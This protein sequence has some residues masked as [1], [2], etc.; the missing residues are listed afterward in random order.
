MIEPTESGKIETDESNN[1]NVAAE[2]ATSSTSKAKRFGV[3]GG[4][5]IV[6]FVVLI[7]GRGTTSNSIS[8]R[9]DSIASSFK[10]P[11]C[12]G[13]SVA[14]SKA[15]TSK[16]IYEEIQRRVTAGESDATIRT[17]LVTRFGEEQ[18]LRPETTGIGSIA[19]IAPVVLVVIALGALA[20]TFLR[21]RAAPVHVS[22]ADRERV[23]NA[24]AESRKHQ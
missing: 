10:C 7:V 12:Q 18:L 15:S 19:W 13:Q 8:A 2:V 16:A 9:T 21:G 5:A 23:A 17:Y 1:I 3:I 24:L 14:Q 22:A 4:L 6:A 20:R 11:V